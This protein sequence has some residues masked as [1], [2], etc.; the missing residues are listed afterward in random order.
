MSEE[1]TEELA[2]I[3]EENFDDAFDENEEETSLHAIDDKKENLQTH[4]KIKSN[5]CGT[6]I[7]L[8]AGYSKTT[9]LTTK[10]MIVDELGLIHSGFIFGAADY[11]AAVAVNEPNVVIIGSRSKFL[12]PAKLDDLVEFEAKAKF[13]DS[14]KREIK[15]MG[16]INEIKIYEGI[17]H[18]IV[19]EQHIFKTKIKNADRSYK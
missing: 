14:R 2:E 6:I 13:E 12:A 16:F 8:E 5:L 15:V 19:L 18:A 10:E 7:S 3:E 17:F 9:L 4:G 11:A 1:I